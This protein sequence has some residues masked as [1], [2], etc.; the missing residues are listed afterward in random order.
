MHYKNLVKAKRLDRSMND[1]MSRKARESYV[2]V[3]KSRR[4]DDILDFLKKWRIRVRI[5]RRKLEKA[6]QENQPTLSR[7]NRKEYQI[8]N[9]DLGD[10]K[11]R[12]A[13]VGLFGAFSK[14]VS[15]GRNT[16]TGASKILHVMVPNLF[17]M[18]D[19]AIR[20]AYAC[21][22][23]DAEHGEDYF[24]FLKRTQSELR[25]A[26]RSYGI[27]HSCSDEEAM[28]KISEELFEPGYDSFSRL[29]DCYNYQKFTLGKDELWSNE[30]I[31]LTAWSA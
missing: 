12:D 24:T 23:Q 25:E 5:D 29:I 30:W 3:L 27:Q 6:I 18:W 21:R 2:Q 28:K 20:W 26:V 14:E 17:V 4:V 11:T 31:D 19:D 8:A 10:P 1:E 7:L 22:S 16:Y 9:V 15:I 13:I